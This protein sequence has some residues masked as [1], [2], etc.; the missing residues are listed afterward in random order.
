[1]VGPTGIEPVTFGFVALPDELRA[2]GKRSQAT[3]SV[4]DSQKSVGSASHEFT[5]L[6]TPRAT[7]GLPDPKAMG[8]LTVREVAAILRVSTATVYSLVAAGK[9]EHIRISNA[10]RIKQSS[11]IG[12][13]F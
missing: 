12:K 10:I 13:D 9:L 4:P 11:M 2:D 5:A 8:L 3:D 6:F 1:M 7:R